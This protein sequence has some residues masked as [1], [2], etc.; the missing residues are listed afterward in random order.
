M[1]TIEG[2]EPVFRY[3]IQCLKLLTGPSLTA[4]VAGKVR[5]M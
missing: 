1:R 5:D 3:F 2:V 4:K